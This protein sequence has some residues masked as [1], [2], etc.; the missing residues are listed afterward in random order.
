[1]RIAILLAGPMRS[2]PEVISNHKQ[3]VGDYDT[4]VSCRE[5]DYNDWIKS[6]W[7]PKKI[8][9]TPESD[10]INNWEYSTFWQFWNIRN[11]ILN[12]PKYDL[13]IKSRNDLIFQ[14]KLLISLEAIKNNELWNPDKM[15]WGQEWISNGTMNDQFYIGD[16]NVMNIIANFIISNEPNNDLPQTQLL[17]WLLNNGIEYKKF[18]EFHFTKNH[19][20]YTHMEALKKQI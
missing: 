2:L 9:I 10:I 11:V 18:S 20:G 3:M 7:N 15:F 19:F 1:M 12:T 17:K 14:N 8:Y 5:E 6:D 16:I 13:Y 4:F